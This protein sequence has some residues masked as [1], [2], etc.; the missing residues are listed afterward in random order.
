MFLDKLKKK[1]IKRKMIQQSIKNAEV[2][3]VKSERKVNSILLFTADDLIV[4]FDKILADKLDVDIEQI[5]S[6]KYVENHSKESK[7][8]I[9]YIS[10]S[11]ISVFGKIKNTQ[12]QESIDR[13]YDL[14]INFSQNNLILN[15]L[16]TVSNAQ[17]KVGLSSDS[18]DFYDLTIDIPQ[19]DFDVFVNELKKY[20][21][22]LKKL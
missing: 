16:A 14:L 10:K 4:D 8:D 19:L 1:Q 21:T 6:L 12:L 20:L 15:Y 5:T 18:V 11:D 3:M 13:K 2:S 17:F 9:N 7:E 22:I